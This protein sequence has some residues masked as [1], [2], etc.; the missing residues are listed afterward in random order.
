MA[1]LKDGY[2]K[3]IGSA[4]GN[5]SYALLAGGGHLS[6]SAS[7]GANALVQ[8][9]ASGYIANNYFYTSSGG[10]ERNASGLGYIAGFNTGDYYI[11]SYTSAAVKTWLGLGTNAYSDIAYLPLTGGIINGTLGF[12]NITTGTR[13][14]NSYIADNDGWY[15]QGEG[16]AQN[17]GALRIGTWDDSNEPIM[18]S[19]GSSNTSFTRTA[20][21]LDSSGNTSFPGNVTAPSFIGN[22]SGTATASTKLYTDGST[23]GSLMTFNWSGP[24]GQPTWLWGGND[25]SNMYVYNPSNFSVNYATTSGLTSTLDYGGLQ[26][27]DTSGTL[28]QGTKFYGVYNN[29]YPTMYGNVLN[30]AGQGYGQL[31]IGWSGTTGAHADNY[32]RSL[33]D[34]AK[35]TN[36]WSDWA[37]ILTSANY[38]SYAIPLSGGTI[39]GSLTVSS[40]LTANSGIELYGATPYIDFHFNNSA[41]DYTS[42]IVESTSGTLTTTGAFKVNGATTLSS[43]LG[44]T[45]LTTLG[46]GLLVSS[47]GININ[48]S[49]LWW[50]DSGGTTVYSNITS[51][52]SAQ[53]SWQVI[54]ANG[55]EIWFGKRG[56]KRILS[57]VT[58]YDTAHNIS[59]AS[60]TTI[61]FGTSIA[62]RNYTLQVNGTL[63]TQDSIF[64]NGGLS[65]VGGITSSSGSLN[66]LGGVTAGGN[67][68]ANEGYF[69]GMV[70]AGGKVKAYGGNRGN[71]L[72]LLFDGRFG[73]DTSTS[74][75]VYN[76]YVNRTGP[77][78]PTFAR[79]AAGVYTLTFS[80]PTYMYYIIMYS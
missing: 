1:K 55:T 34:S 80:A 9:D 19:Q 23:A 51:D 16:T 26:T 76:V 44:V 70:E 42:R 77:S 73:Y 72:T 4:E 59:T 30:I 53:A 22:L 2:F 48:A 78:N 67:V 13:G 65:V 8:R 69:T 20:Y 12:A 36:G 57:M 62:Q 21:L 41:S 64:S 71:I 15:I 24:G 25:S 74:S 6:Y 60:Y 46:G 32:I 17:N 18:V 49:G 40:T 31:L 54:D 63:Y 39:T 28:T 50:K 7:G 37:K 3:N 5:D 79:T 43:T 68:S 45:G 10:A 14:L 33:R 35:G 11:R 56:G 27:M 66:V 58:Q 75:N 61:G 38:G 47:G 52:S 29:G